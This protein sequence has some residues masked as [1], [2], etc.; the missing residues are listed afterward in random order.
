MRNMPQG[1][2]PSRCE[3][4]A[5]P[6]AGSM[7]S[8]FG[9]QRSSVVTSLWLTYAQAQDLGGQVRKGEKGSLVVY[10]N[11]IKRTE[12]NETTGEETERDIPFLKSYVVFNAEQ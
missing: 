2:S 9:R 11:S 6:I 10:A 8:C 5:C 1:G 12:Q 3:R 7:S 4:M